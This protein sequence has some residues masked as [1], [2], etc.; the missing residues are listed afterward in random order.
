M[1]ARAQKIS[2]GEQGAAAEVS[3]DSES[4]GYS[5]STEYSPVSV[6]E[7]AVDGKSDS[8]PVDVEA[9][10][11]V[12]DARGDALM[13]K[14]NP[15]LGRCNAPVWLRQL[16]MPRGEVAAIQNPEEIQ[17]TADKEDRHK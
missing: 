1:E 6:D 7:R 17:G 12:P 9:M 8:G 13:V 14:P 16:L 4:S 11:Q 5:M 15:N 10:S 3:S 2:V